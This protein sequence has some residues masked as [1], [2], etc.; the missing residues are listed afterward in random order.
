M[1]ADEMALEYTKRTGK[2][3]RVTGWPAGLA[4]S[5]QAKSGRVCHVIIPID[6]ESRPR[7]VDALVY[8]IERDL[9]DY[10]IPEDARGTPAQPHGLGQG[11]TAPCQIPL[12]TGHQL[13]PVND[14]TTR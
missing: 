7:A 13:A 3:C 5:A 2:E 4:I 12:K 9:D 6:D 10:R 11:P 1:T 14:A 8:H